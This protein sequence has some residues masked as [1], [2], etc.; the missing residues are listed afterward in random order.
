MWLRSALCLNLTLLVGIILSAP[1]FVRADPEPI[2]DDQPDVQAPALGV[3]VIPFGVDSAMRTQIGRLLV[4]GLDK[5]DLNDRLEQPRFGAGVGA[6]FATASQG[7][8]EALA[9]LAAPVRPV[10]DPVRDRKEMVFKPNPNPRTPKEKEDF[11]Q[12]LAEY[13]ALCQTLNKAYIYRP[14]QFAASAEKN[15]NRAHLMATPRKHRGTVVHI[16]GDL[17]RIEEIPTPL[18][19]RPGGVRHVYEGI[20]FE[21]PDDSGVTNAWCLYFTELPDGITAGDKLKHRVSF[22]GYFFKIRGYQSEVNGSEKL[23]PVLIGHQPVPKDKPEAIAQLV[24]E[25]KELSPLLL[26][27]LLGVIVLVV[28][29]A[30]FLTLWFRGG[31]REVRQKLAEISARRFV[32]PSEQPPPEFEFPPLENAPSAPNEELAP[33]TDGT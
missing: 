7:P 14:P 30:I 20:L 3:P 6:F 15:V 19:I 29:L 31:D 5:A 32:D 8:L 16:E 4:E 1:S 2:K 12:Q 13:L 25:M 26:Y 27:G 17:V 33:P 18:D 21:D 23:A 24:A 10:W 11:D 22:D 9:F 28:G